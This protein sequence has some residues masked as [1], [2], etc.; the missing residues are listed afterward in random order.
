MI[1]DAPL[2]ATTKVDGVLNKIAAFVEVAKS[3]AADGLT[4]AE[5]GELM[6]SLLH[7]VVEQIDS[8]TTMTGE[9]KKA[10]VLAAVGSLFDAV[11]G[12]AVPFFAK[13][14]WLAVRPAVRSLILALASGGV[15]QIL[16][17]VRA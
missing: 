10:L 11:A 16:K 1:A 17:L 14:L 2:A 12:L 15:E 8:V 9:Q 4:W 6:I 3:A 7:L 5:F 13:P